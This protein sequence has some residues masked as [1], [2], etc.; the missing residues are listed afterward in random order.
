[1]PADPQRVQAIFLAA[2]EQSDPTGRAALLTRE[3]GDDVELRQRVEDLLQAHDEPQSFLE[4]PAAPYLPTIADPSIPEAPGTVIGP[5]KLL[6]QIGEGGFGVVFMAE[7]THPVR[8]KVALKILKPGMDTRQVV[9]RF[10]AERQAL[11]IMDHPNIAKVHDGG[12]T[13]SGRP[14]FVMELV[15]GIPI[16]EYCDQHHLTPRQRLELFVPVCHAVQHAHQ[17][18]IIH[19]DL[20]PSNVLVSVHDTVPVVK[21]IDFGVAKAL[22]QELTEKTLFTGFAQ[23]VG[24][25][26]YMS[27]EQAGESGLDIDTRSDI[28]SLGVLLY[29]L[30]TGTTPLS[31]ERFK[32]AAYDEIR[33]IIREEEPQKPSTRLS[34]LSKVAAACQAAGKARR[35]A[36]AG[37]HSQT[38][39]SLA[40]ISAVRNTEPKRLAQLLRGDLDWIVMKA[41]EKDRNRR[42][43]TANS[44]AADIVRYLSD[45]PV[46]ACPPSAIYRFRKFAQRNRVAFTTGAVVAVALLVAIVGTT[47]GLLQAQAERDHALDAKEKERLALVEAEENLQTARDAVDKTYTR[48]AEEMADKPQ[49][50]QLRRALLEDALKFYRGFLKKKSTDRAIRYESALSQRR[51]GEIYG[52]L[53][54]LK[55]SLENHRQAA[56]TLVALAPQY[57]N[58]VKYRDELAR[59]HFHTGYALLSLLQLDEGAARMEQAMALWEPL[60]TEFPDR[61]SYLEDLAR[62][63]FALG[64]ALQ[65]N[66]RPTGQPYLTRGNELLAKFKQR[67][68]G[69]EI[70]TGFQFDLKSLVA[71]RYSALPHDAGTLQ[72]LEKECRDQLAAAE[73]EARN[74][75]DAPRYEGEVAAWVWRLGNV[76]AA[77]DRPEEVV[78]FRMRK[79]EICKR[80]ATQHPD[81]PEFQRSLAWAH[82]DAGQVLHEAG[83]PDEALGHFRTAIG[84]ASDLV[85]KYPDHLRP[86]MHL[87]EMIR[88]CPAPQLRDPQRV[89]EL[90]H[91][92]KELGQKDGGDLAVAQMDA[93][94]YREALETCEELVRAGDRT[95]VIGY[96]TAVAYWHLGRHAEARKLAR[97]VILQMGTQ[98]NDKWYAP[99]FRRRAREVVTLMGLESEDAKTT[100][101]E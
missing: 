10:E 19:R 54:E 1:M 5:Y 82:Y 37:G 62:T 47:A 16:T 75:P 39:T 4:R 18:G 96:V 26:L 68:P 101:P 100:N 36:A 14:Y 83:R 34:E 15:K 13:P 9:A 78:Q 20:K 73:A 66:Y 40:S 85:E 41:L 59:A 46:A 81:A 98:P 33:R 94:L 21:V 84:L 67:F 2:A 95:A 65:R 45:E 22:G 43:E 90:S 25:P 79:L 7:Q 6:E 11:A 91:S 50:E 29:E 64:Q 48:A 23:M 74:Y 69:R 53:G 76:L 28:Y 56:T 55:E 57:V 63:N 32:Q 52:F 92:M 3:C 31:K 58:D 88:F 97:Q 51:V 60:A 61:P 30:L 70:S 44:F 71:W 49:L 42:Y 24:T 38:R 93:G 80:I 72:Q 12:S 8:R 87:T 86:L 77:L 27:P 35:N 89:L 17:K 99:E